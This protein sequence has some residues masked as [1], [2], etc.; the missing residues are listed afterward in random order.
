ME[1]PGENW[2]EIVRTVIKRIIVHKDGRT[3]I[4]AIIPAEAAQSAAELAPGARSRERI[5]S[6]RRRGAAA[7]RGDRRPQ[8]PESVDQLLP[9]AL[10][11]S[12]ETVQQGA[13][14]ATRARALSIVSSIKM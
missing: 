12:Q 8:P 6:S 10:R 11:E 9:V 13:H 7:E 4:E 1:I 5:Q 2:V 3:R 14:R